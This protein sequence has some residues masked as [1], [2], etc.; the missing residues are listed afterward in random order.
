M[1]TVIP[2]RHAG[3]GGSAGEPMPYH[4]GS[5]TDRCADSDARD[6]VSNSCLRPSLQTVKPLQVASLK[7]CK[8]ERF[9]ARLHLKSEPP[10]HTCNLQCLQCLVML[11]ISDEAP[12]AGRCGTPSPP[13]APAGRAAGSGPG[14]RSQPGRTRTA[15][16]PSGPYA[17][18][19]T[20][21]RSEPSS[22]S[23]PRRGRRRRRSAR[24][25]NGPGPSDS[26]DQCSPGLAGAGLVKPRAA[27]NSD[28]P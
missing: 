21:S 16:G 3:G 27:S 2:R 17:A 4:Y 20:P 23:G 12:P 13:P 28:Y 22:S 10:L 25:H 7:R 1:R 9:D 19:P 26:S 18:G 6:S 14:S 5:V 15:H 24:G 11:I 8:S